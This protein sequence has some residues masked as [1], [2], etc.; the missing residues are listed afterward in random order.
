MAIT[1]AAA[2]ASVLLTFNE[3]DFRG[4]VPDLEI[5]VPSARA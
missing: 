2:G 3:R 4:L 5:V 1:A